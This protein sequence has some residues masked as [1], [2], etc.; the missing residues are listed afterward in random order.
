MPGAPRSVRP[1]HNDPELPEWITPKD[2]ERAARIELKTLTM[3]NADEVARHLA[4]VP[5]LI[6][7][8]PEL[9]HRHAAAAVRRAGRIAI[10][11]E[12][13]AITAYET[14]D[15]ALALREL[16]TYRRI[17]G[18]D[19]QLPLMVDS[20]RGVGR[21]DRALEVGRSV[22][23]SQLSADV[24][25]ALAI[26][27]SGA[28]LDLG[29]TE[30]ALAELEIPQLDKT[31]A[32]SYSP[33][34]FDAYATVLEDLGRDAE[35]VSWRTL[36]ETAREALGF[37]DEEDLIEVDV[38]ELEFDAD[39][40]VDVDVVDNEPAEDTSSVETEDESVDDA[41]DAR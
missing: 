1:R 30:A 11:R 27:M 12:T 37:N 4:M 17:S 15:F 23:R 28:R 25:V 33:A 34:L 26:A 40:D 13:Y 35:G 32:F 9:A 7:S 16:R 8:D 18:K 3:E 41:G 19:D 10:V 14:G 38:E 2:L 21:P 24:Q 22:D 31:R 6:E 5:R 39:A 20:E 29:Q 36:A